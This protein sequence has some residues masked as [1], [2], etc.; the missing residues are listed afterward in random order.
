MAINRTPFKCAR[1]RDT[2]ALGFIVLEQCFRHAKTLVARRTNEPPGIFDILG[3]TIGDRETA[4]H[5]GAELTVR[6]KPIAHCARRAIIVRIA[7]LIVAHSGHAAHGEPSPIKGRAG[8]D[9]DGAGNGIGVL[10]GNETLGDFEVGNDVRWNRV[11]VDRSCCR[12]DRND[13]H[14]I[15]RDRAE[16]RRTAADIDVAAFALVALD[17]NTRH[18]LQCFGDIR[19]WETAD[20]ICRKHRDGIVRLTLLIE[21]ARG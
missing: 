3:P 11:E 4:G 14:T 12:I 6:A 21:R 1:G 10:T 2:L 19:I 5:D 20:G 8:R 16:F 15:D 9:V 7:I 13:A 17:A 18:A